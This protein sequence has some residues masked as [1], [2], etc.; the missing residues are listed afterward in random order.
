MA[1]F[2]FIR[3]ELRIK[4]KIE[5]PLSELALWFTL[6]NDILYVHDRENHKELLKEAIEKEKGSPH[7]FLNDKYQSYDFLQGCS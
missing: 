7:I 5:K 1:G 6:E 2:K 3:T 4:C